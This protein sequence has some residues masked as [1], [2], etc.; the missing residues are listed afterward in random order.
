MNLDLYSTTAKS[1]IQKL[2]IILG[3]LIFIA[4]SIYI[5]LKNTSLPDMDQITAKEFAL[6]VLCIFN[7]LNFLRFLI[8]LFIFI[9]R[10]IPYEEMFSVLMAFGLYYI[11]FILL[12]IIIDFHN[13]PLIITGIALFFLG[14]FFNTFSELQ[15]HQWKRDDTNKGKIYTG[16][17]FSVSRHPN[18]FGDLL[19]VIGYALV[20]ANPFSVLVPVL[21]FF[22][23]YLYNIPMQ[24]KHMLE[25]YG[26]AYRK[27][28]K[29]V[30]KFI[31]FVC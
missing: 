13:V 8:T 19:W 2:T 7:I 17:L 5:M 23:F 11:G 1:T 16:G 25:K 28:S 21:I 12:A 15:R 9:K 26:E 24:E 20:S 29:N 14:C 18:F 4:V 22:F 10:R 3:Q 30:K 6:M 31:P 27:Y